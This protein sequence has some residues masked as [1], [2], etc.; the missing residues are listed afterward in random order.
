MRQCIS[1]S[2]LIK[3]LCND[4]NRVTNKMLITDAMNRM[5]MTMRFHHLTT[6]HR[7]V[8]M[9][10]TASFELVAYLVR[11]WSLSCTEGKHTLCAC[12]QLKLTLAL[13]YKKITET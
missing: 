12:N 1:N 3:F 6:K 11:L 2:N 4:I 13:L 5:A 7:S 8:C 9:A 10:F